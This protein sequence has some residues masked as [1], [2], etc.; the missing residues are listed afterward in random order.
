MGCSK[1]VALRDSFDTAGGWSSACAV[2]LAG[3][4]V[5]DAARAAA[6]PAYDIVVRTGHDLR[7]LGR[8]ALHGR[9]RD[10]GRPHRLCRAARAGR[11]RRATIDAHGQGRVARLHQHAVVGER[12]A[13]GRRPRTKRSAPGRDAGSD[14]RRRV[15]GPAERRDEAARRAARRATS[16][17]PSTGRRW[18]NTSPKAA[19]RSGISPNVASFVGAAT[20]RVHELGEG[21]VEPT[22]EQ[23][24]RMRRWCTRRWR[25]ARWAWP[26]SLI[27]APGTYAEDAGTHRAGQ[28]G[29][30]LRRHVHL[31]HAQRRRPAD[32]G[33]GRTDRASPRSRARPPRSITSRSRASR[34][35]TSCP[36]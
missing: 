25:K 32:R 12:I 8:R 22:P 15:H 36:R 3:C 28:R 26:P 24:A 7:R 2:G 4:G 27:Y 11:P 5:R 6:P 18:A 19:G 1:R 20:A 35:G 16:S 9:R 17:I 10:Q 33:D 31:A 30:A 14:G 13:S 29:G 34:T 23:L 21:D